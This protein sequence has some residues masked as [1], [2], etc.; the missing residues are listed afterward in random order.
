[1]RCSLNRKF[2]QV[3]EQIERGRRLTSYVR[4]YLAEPT[5]RGWSRTSTPIRERPLSIHSQCVLSTAK[6]LEHSNK[7]QTLYFSLK[8]HTGT[9][10]SEIDALQHGLFT[11]TCR[12]FNAQIVIIWKLAKKTWEKIRCLQKKFLIF[13]V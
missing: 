8:S 11:A 1:M 12:Y 7:Q 9:L 2:H 10:H 13:T 3:P 4:R 6:F 5:L